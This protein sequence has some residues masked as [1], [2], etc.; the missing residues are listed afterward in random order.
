[1]WEFSIQ[2]LK[3]SHSFWP[4]RSLDLFSTSF[5][6]YQMCP[7][8]QV[9]SYSIAPWALCS[10]SLRGF[11]FYFNSFHKFSRL[12]FDIVTL[13]P[14]LFWIF[15]FMTRS[16]ATY[17]IMIYAAVLYHS[18]STLFLEGLWLLKSFNSD[19]LFY[20]YNNCMDS[21]HF[22]SV[23]TYQA[24]ITLWVWSGPQGDQTSPS[25]GNQSWIFIGRT[26]AKAETSILWPPDAKNWL[27]GKDPDTGKDW[28]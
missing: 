27:T 26:D 21:A 17:F 10:S 12:P 22:F 28:R 5:H 1:M 14:F 8:L 3:F 6:I 15:E 9:W 25:K 20:S 19:F 4:F 13:C 11:V 23:H 18:F 2:L 24:E 16:A 7:P